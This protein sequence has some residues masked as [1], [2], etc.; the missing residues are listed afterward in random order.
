M[1]AIET[2]FRKFATF[3][4]RAGR[5][6]FWTFL[7]FALVLV[8]APFLVDRTAAL[9][10]VIALALLLP[11][12]AVGVRR[13]HDTGHSGLWL[14]VTFIPFGSLFL[15]YLWAKAGDEAD[16]RYGPPTSA[17]PKARVAA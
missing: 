16:N 3:S 11:Y 13:L 15:L 4:G 9:S 1:E 5:T 7:V 6:E 2:C 14:L 10:S 8:W 17:Q 12:L